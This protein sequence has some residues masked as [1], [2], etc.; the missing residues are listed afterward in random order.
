MFLLND[1][2]R[3]FGIST[4]SKFFT[5]EYFEGNELYDFDG[6]KDESELIKIL[7]QVSTVLYY[8]H[9]SA[10]IYYDLKSENILVRNANGKP[11]V[12][13]IDFGLASHIREDSGI[14]A[15]GTAEYIA[16]EILRKDKI[17][18]R[19][20]LYSL[21]I[22]L[23]KIIYGKFPFSTNDQISIYKAHLDQQFDFPE[24]N[25]SKK[26]VN[27]VKRLLSKEVEQR[28]YTSIGILEEF[29]PSNIK[30]YKNDWTR[31][32]VFTGRNDSLSVIST[33]IEKENRGEVLIV[34]GS[35]GAGK[36]TL[37]NELDYKYGD[38]IFISEEQN[39]ESYL[40]QSLLRKIL[41]KQN[42][43]SELSPEVVQKGREI[44]EGKSKSLIED[45][46][47]LFIVLSSTNGFILLIDDFNLISNFDFE[48][49]LQLIP[50]LQVGKIKIVIAED[51]VD[52]SRS[53]R[54][55][56][57]QVI[58]LNPFTEA[59]VAEFIFKS[60]AP[61]FPRNE[62]RKTIIIYS[63]L[64]PGSIEIFL[65]DLI[66]LNFLEFFTD[67]P[68]MNVG[69]D[70]DTI[71]KSSQEEIYQ[72]RL[73]DLEEESRDIVIFLSMFNISLD[74]QT[75]C[76]LTGKAR[77][78][79]I[80]ILEKISESNIIHQSTILNNP[81]F[82]S[83]GIKEYIYSTINN[84][85]QSHLKVS[86]VIIERLPSFDR[87]E[88]ARHLELAGEFEKS[89]EVLKEEIEKADKT[90]ALSY[91]KN[92]LQHLEN[93]PLSKDSQRNIKID[94][95]NCLFQL[96]EL[97]ASLTLI[98]EL[99]DNPRSQNEELSL[100]I[101]KGKVLIALQSLEEGK[102][103]LESILS[104]IKE[105]EMKEELLSEIAKVEYEMGNY[106]EAESK[107]NQLIEKL[108]ESNEIEAKMYTIKGLIE[109]YKNNNPRK[110]LDYFS[111]SR[112]IYFKL[113][114]L[115]N[116]AAMENNIGNIYNFINEKNNA[117]I[118]WNKAVEINNSIGNL[119]YKSIIILNN[120][121]FYLE[122]CDYEKAIDQYLIAQSIFSALGEKNNLGI[123]F[124][125]LGEAYLITCEYENAFN[126]LTSA[127]SLYEE[128][129]NKLEEG[130]AILLMGKLFFELRDSEKLKELIQSYHNDFLNES[131]KLGFNY[132]YL[133]VLQKIL[134]EQ[135][136][137]L[138]TDLFR[139]RD[140]SKNYSDNFS[141][142]DI[143][144]KLIEELIK[145][146]NFN[147][148]YN[149]LMKEDFIKIS[150]NNTYLGSYR[151]FLFGKLSEASGD[152]RLKPSLVYF[153]KAFEKIRDISITELT[154]KILL[155]LYQAYE[156]RGNIDRMS[157][158]KKLT[159][160]TIYF[161]M[162]QIEQLPDN[163][164]YKSRSEWKNVIHK[165][166]QETK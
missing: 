8:L 90:S 127:V 89:Y 33:Y 111:K 112:N 4:G 146:K 115:S 66:V 11:V 25:Y 38:S 129:E 32:P 42:I 56:N 99:L 7:C 5:L 121:I 154:W 31:I 137:D 36:S 134:G 23:Y 2:D 150:A 149:E 64:L 18:H 13:F 145:N 29:Y 1:E 71:L 131:D 80:S 81:Q 3:E 83:Q 41:Y 119:L 124:T 103:L 151:A 110:T 98:D 101:L 74:V 117:E 88:L 28:C 37:L 24:S 60:F 39:N 69:D 128:L 116:F 76:K 50:V 9:Q 138:L 120:G 70:F 62:I 27:L 144:I 104:E 59:Q 16:P 68:V 79:I 95:S 77:V 114:S 55:N 152:N 19:V 54:I 78:Q 57:L 51:S 125:N 140:N 22:L 46:K 30:N 47:A 97:N 148:A 72:L 20:D 156:K 65:K 105:D 106:N 107:A 100:K 135:S 159:L 21:G 102:T 92:L 122:S 123:T 162:E 113:N 87:N 93:L 12:K 58:N 82:T 109:F 96:S 45:L 165:L 142:S 17:D 84:K 153:E 94:L 53:G 136:Q 85:R 164:L 147:Q 44:L 157:E 166:E 40:W 126:V 75:I 67:G 15:K 43:F 73:Y 61:F 6:I 163:E 161:I 139:L 155:S 141:Y 10:F 26:I 14:H 130:E 86:N 133:S 160:N 34:K 91:K 158:Y 143:Q 63:D 132:H 48:I 52:E 118:H 108:T 35:E 49:F